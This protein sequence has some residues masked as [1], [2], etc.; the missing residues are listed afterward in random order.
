[1]LG[2][3]LDTASIGSISYRYRAKGLRTGG[4]GRL[5]FAQKGGPFDGKNCFVLPDVV[6]DGEWHTVTL[7]TD[8]AIVP[9]AWKAAGRVCSIR[10]DP[11]YSM[12]EEYELAFIRFERTLNGQN[13]NGK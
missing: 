12:E 11:A 8:K 3:D 4:K 6:T 13:T 1:M 10:F 7:M 5:F 9:Q 2:L